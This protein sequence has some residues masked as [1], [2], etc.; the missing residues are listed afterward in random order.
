MSRNICNRWGRKRGKRRKD[1]HLSSSWARL[2]FRP[3]CDTH[4]ILLKAAPIKH[5]WIWGTGFY[6]YFYLWKLSKRPKYLNLL[7]LLEGYVTHRFPADEKTHM[8][9]TSWFT[10]AGSRRRR[11]CHLPPYPCLLQEVTELKGKNVQPF[12]VVS[13]QSSA[14]GSI[15]LNADPPPGVCVGCLYCFSWRVTIVSMCNG[16]PPTFFEKI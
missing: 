11:Q 4:A 9:C 7:A 8:Y 14:P 3:V 12:L 13:C 16:P 1:V 6:L 15:M 2:L 5:N 10:V